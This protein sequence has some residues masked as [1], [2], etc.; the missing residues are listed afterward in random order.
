MK[1][2]ENEVLRE[3]IMSLRRVNLLHQVR[4]STEG[5]SPEEVRHVGIRRLVH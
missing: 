1:H 5:N 4:I 3:F 2:V